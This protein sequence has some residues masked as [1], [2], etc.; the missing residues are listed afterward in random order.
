MEVLVS[1]AQQGGARERAIRAFSNGE[2][3]RARPVTFGVRY[4][5]SCRMTES[6]R[7]QCRLHGERRPTFVC[8]HLVQGTGLGFLEGQPLSDDD[9]REQSAWCDECEEVRIKC[10][11][12]WIDESEGFAGVTMICDLCFEAA[13]LRNSQSNANRAWW[14]FW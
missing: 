4:S 2:V 9:S 14:K 6:Q 10:G 1:N 13:R 11:G 8:R 7:V 5:W 3:T 12:S